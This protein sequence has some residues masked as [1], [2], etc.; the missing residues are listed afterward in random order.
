M[1]ELKEKAALLHSQGYNCAQSVCAVFADKLP[2][3]EDT[4]FKLTEGFGAGTGNLQGSCGALSAA[5]MIAGLFNSGGKDSEKKTKG[6]T[7]RLTSMINK[8]FEKK[9]GAIYCKDIKGV[10][11]G[12]VLRSCDGCID[13]A[14]DIIRDLIFKD[15]Q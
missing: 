11:T 14:I 8:E 9:A 12:K 5:V 15:Q 10:G 1:D 3:D 4:L 6:Q 2:L 7:Y 13:D